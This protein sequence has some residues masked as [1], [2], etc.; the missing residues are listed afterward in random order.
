MTSC[1]MHAGA[2]VGGHGRAN[3]DQTRRMQAQKMD[4]GGNAIIYELGCGSRHV[5]REGSEQ[6]QKKRNP[7][8]AGAAGARSPPP[9]KKNPKEEGGRVRLCR[10]RAEALIYGYQDPPPGVTRVEYYQK[11]NKPQRENVRW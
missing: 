10:V 2:G 3:T 5:Q 9:P 8:P 1:G 7:A 4:R 11:G 6:H